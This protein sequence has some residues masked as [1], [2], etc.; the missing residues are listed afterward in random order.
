[1]CLSNTY[2]EA[3]GT[4]L[5]SNTSKVDLLE[6]GTLCVRN[7]FGEEVRVRGI[8]SAVDFEQ[9]TLVIRCEE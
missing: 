1:M 9:N 5:L 7:L 2:K 4:L 6:D 3:D 8:I